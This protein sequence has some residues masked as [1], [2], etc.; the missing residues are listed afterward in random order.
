MTAKEYKIVIGALLVVNMTCLIIISVLCGEINLLQDKLSE[1][2]DTVRA[3]DEKIANIE[4]IQENFHN[5][6]S[7]NEKVMEKGNKYILGGILVIIGVVIVTYLGGGIDPG[8]LGK[9]FNL[10]AD[11]STVDLISQNDLISKNLK[12]CL[13]SI[14]FMNKSI[15]A[16][17]G[18]KTDFI[19]S[20]LEV[21][22]K[23]FIN[24]EINL[25]SIF[26]NLPSDKGKD[27]E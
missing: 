13:Q 1:M 16:E 20:K 27:W 9:V 4:V 6:S 11:Q 14:D 12:F 15:V 18:S 2:S 25:N 8:N 19:C 26:G 24:K 23:A 17:I 5:E 21:I 10:S 3:L 7:Q 22:T